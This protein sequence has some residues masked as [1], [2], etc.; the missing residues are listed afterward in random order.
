MKFRN[1]CLVIM[2]DTKNVLGEI[3]KISETQPSV[4]DANGILIATFMSNADPKELGDYFKLN[5]RNFLLFDLNEENSSTYFAKKEINDGLFGF[6][7]EMGIDDLKQKTDE[8]IDEITS[9]TKTNRVMNTNKKIKKDK[10]TV[11]DI[12]NMS[13]TAKNELMNRLIDKGVENLS[14]DDK[15]ILN[16]LVI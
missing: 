3:L 6:L 16:K 4:L 15:M 14:E 8:L 9:T 10:I 1:F 11:E 7:K 12:E 5:G 2:G 13:P